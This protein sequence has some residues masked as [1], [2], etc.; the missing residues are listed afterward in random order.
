M[1]WSQ[2]FAMGGYG[3]FVWASY[4]VF[5]IILIWMML[6]PLVKRRNLMKQLRQQKALE[7]RRSKS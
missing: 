3:R 5:T 6:A 4:G 1:D 2:F 7:R